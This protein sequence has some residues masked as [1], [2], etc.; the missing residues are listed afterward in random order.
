MT[1]YIYIYGPSELLC[2]GKKVILNRGWGGS[3]AGHHICDQKI[4]GSIPGSSSGCNFL[5]QGQFFVLILDHGCT[6]GY[7]FSP[8]FIFPSIQVILPEVQVADF[9]S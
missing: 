4:A 5:L 3:V 9:S 8:P 1:A 7:V 6:Y 2:S